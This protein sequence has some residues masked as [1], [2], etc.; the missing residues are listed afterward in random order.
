MIKSIF[1]GV[2]AGL[3]LSE[4]AWSGLTDGVDAFNSGDYVEAYEQLDPLADEGDPVAQFYL[5]NMFL[6][7]QG[8]PLDEL[9]AVEWLRKS[10]QQGFL[11]AQR[12]LASIYY[13]GLLDVPPDLQKAA[14]W[15]RASAEQGH[16]VSQL[17]LAAMYAEGKGVDQDLAESEKWM[18]KSAEQGELEAQLI[19]A[20]AYVEE[21]VFGFNAQQSSRWL[22]VASQQQIDLLRQGLKDQGIA[23]V[24]VDSALEEGQK[25]NGSAL[26]YIGLAYYLGEGVPQDD[27]KSLTYLAVSSTFEGGENAHRWKRVIEKLVN[28]DQLEQAHRLTASCYKSKLMDCE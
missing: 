20:R 10:A 2:V 22:R 6:N 8:V 25:L 17:A 28:P 13:N 5:G 21:R 18:V 3:L 14:K 11:S 15:H 1:A 19:L 27:V 4:I 7:G 9:K 24:T 12:H 23:N 16:A 26:F